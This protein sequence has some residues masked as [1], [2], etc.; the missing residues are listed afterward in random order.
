MQQHRQQQQDQFLDNRMVFIPNPQSSGLYGGGPLNIIL[1]PKPGFDES[2]SSR[3]KMD[4]CSLT[5]S[6][7]AQ[8]P[9]LPASKLPFAWKLYEMLETVEKN[10]TDTDI[11]SWV[12]NGEAFKVHDLER[13]VEDIIPT[14]FKQ[15]KYKSFQRQL[16]FYGFQ[17]VTSSERQGHTVGSYRNPMFIRGNKPLC[18]SMVPKKSKKRCKKS[19]DDSINASSDKNKETSFKPKTV[20]IGTRDDSVSNTV[21]DPSGS[22]E[23]ERFDNA[24]DSASFTKQIHLQKRQREQFFRYIHVVSDETQQESKRVDADEEPCYVFGGKTFHSVSKKSRY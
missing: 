7:L 9:N 4:V 5:L 23:K 21:T 2:H 19:Q 22:H 14:Y 12:D 16:Y 20:S 24:L 15:S 6:S 1:P 11:V 17:R 13:F 8:D 3:A 10:G 18:L